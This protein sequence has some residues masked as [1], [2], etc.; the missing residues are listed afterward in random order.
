M[1]IGAC[2]L[3]A[4]FE[5]ANPMSNAGKKAAILLSEGTPAPYAW[6]AAEAKES[7]ALFASFTSAH[8]WPIV[9]R[10]GTTTR[11]GIFIFYV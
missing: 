2:G 7:G 1:E 4:A 5:T 10:K 6:K 8:S 3:E 9:C 11:A